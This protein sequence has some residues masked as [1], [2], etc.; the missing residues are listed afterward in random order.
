MPRLKPQAKLVLIVLVGGGAVFGLRA[1]MQ[2]GLIPT[3]G[4]MKAIVATRV[5]LPPQQEAQVANVQALPY[6]STSPANVG[7][8]HIQFDVWEWNAMY[9]LIYAKGAAWN[10]SGFANAQLGSL[11]NQYE[12]A[13]SASQQQTLANQ[14][15]TIEWTDVPVIVAAF[16]ESDVY[17]G[18]SVQGSF[19]NGLQFSGGFD[20][21]GI[22]VSGS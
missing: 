8:T 14:I 1:A 6:P 13:T 10:A 4:I 20:L 22:T 15:A 19:P 7:A 16:Q 21:R 18:N 5:D 11:V 17:V 3:P 2:H 9:S 12:A